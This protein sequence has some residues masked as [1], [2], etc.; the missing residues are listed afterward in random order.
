M[1][2]LV[3]I[4]RQVGKKNIPLKVVMTETKKRSKMQKNELNMDL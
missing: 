2:A 1:Q 3:Q 4:E